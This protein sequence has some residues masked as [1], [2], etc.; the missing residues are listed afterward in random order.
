MVS[1]KRVASV[2]NAE[3]HRHNTIGMYSTRNSKTI[4]AVHK[5]ADKMFGDNLEAPE[6]ALRNS[7]WF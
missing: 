2:G 4:L 7:D 3:V 5:L 6:G 1:R